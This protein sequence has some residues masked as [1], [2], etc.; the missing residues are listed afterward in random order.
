[1]F[2]SLNA[3]AENDRLCATKP[4]NQL[5]AHARIPDEKQQ[6]WLKQYRET[7]N[8]KFL[9]RILEANIQLIQI[10]AKQT[11]RWARELD[12]DDLVGQGSLHVLEVLSMRKDSIEQISYFLSDSLKHH[13]FDYASEQLSKSS[14]AGRQRL[15]KVSQLRKTIAE[16]ELQGKKPTVNQLA[17]RLDLRPNE[18]LDLIDLARSPVELDAPISTLDK[19]TRRDAHHDIVSANPPEPDSEPIHAEKV[20]WGS[21]VQ[22][23]LDRNELNG[24]PL[25]EL[26]RAILTERIFVDDDH[27]AL[28]LSE[29]AAKQGVPKDRAT[30]TATRLRAQIVRHL[31]NSGLK[32]PNVASAAP[33]KVPGVLGWIEKALEDGT[34]LNPPLTERERILV[35]RHIL[36]DEPMLLKDLATE[37]GLHPA[38]LV[39]NKSV[40][41][42]KFKNLLEQNGIVAPRDFDIESAVHFEARYRDPPLKEIVNRIL[43]TNTIDDRVLS[44]TEGRIVHKHILTPAPVPLSQIATELGKADVDL[45][46]TK[47]LLTLEIQNAIRRRGFSYSD[48][49]AVRPKRIAIDETQK[50]S[51]G[52]LIRAAIEQERL[53]QVSLSKVE[54]ELL[55]QRIFTDSPTKFSDLEKKLGQDHSTLSFVARKLLL[56]LEGHLLEN[57][58]HELSSL[59]IK[60]LAAFEASNHQRHDFTSI[61]GKMLE[62]KKIGARSLSPPELSILRDRIVTRKPVDDEVLAK[63]LGFTPKHIRKV[64]TKLRD[65]IQSFLNPR[66]PTELLRKL[67]L[68]PKQIE[69]EL[70]ATEMAVFMNLVD[71]DPR[72]PKELAERLGYLESSVYHAKKKLLSKLR[73]YLESHGAVL[74]PSADLEEVIHY[75]VIFNSPDHEATINTAIKNRVLNGKPL[76]EVDFTILKTKIFTPVPVDYKEL[77][78]ETGL[79]NTVLSD[80]EALLRA[81]VTNH[82]YRESVSSAKK[83]RDPLGPSIRSRI[84]RALETGTLGDEPLTAV[85]KAILEDRLFTDKPKP[86]SELLVKAGQKRKEAF[87]KEEPFLLEKVETW[88][89]EQG[90]PPE[91]LYNTVSFLEFEYL[92]QYDKDIATFLTRAVA[93]QEL[94]GH[95]L[96]ERL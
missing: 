41:L 47:A 65:E 73:S 8:P 6:E 30:K 45:E 80:R 60:T 32:L 1:M 57:R 83:T 94:D 27:S 92:N 50:K 58:V 43:S 95:P 11:R 90:I 25:T 34:I 93:T 62:S 84:S 40:L 87:A 39:D 76:D 74:D 79:S 72:S 7:K 42:L 18:V 46:R 82:F 12:L 64:E 2:G 4:K 17:A 81:R 88:L 91:K 5:L 68:N 71:I 51:S 48:G 86:L 16:F 28:R 77:V 15:S 24:R 96:N 69:L 13:F 37:L 78:R 63:S 85:E 49:K 14:G 20:A 56:K 29:I 19:R 23:I 21:A 55:K 59:D 33:V 61:L 3:Y 53:G 31:R 70:N 89:F 67:I 75:H 54:V 66:K 36:A 26:Q 44:S 22:D 10:R 52:D 9:H 38:I 35:T